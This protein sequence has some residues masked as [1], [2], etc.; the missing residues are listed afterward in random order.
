MSKLNIV[1]NGCCKEFKI[2]TGLGSYDFIAK[3]NNISV[4]SLRQWVQ[5]YKIH[6]ASVFGSKSIDSTPNCLK[7]III[8]P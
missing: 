3:N 2:P 1:R 8:K 6:G 4:F 5:K 7:T